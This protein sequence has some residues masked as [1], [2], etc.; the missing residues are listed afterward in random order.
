MSTSAPTVPPS[1]RAGEYATL[2]L[3]FGLSTICVV[4]RMYTKARLLKSLKSED[5]KSQCSDTQ[6]DERYADWYDMKGFHYSATLDF[7]HGWAL[8]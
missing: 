6:P 8:L 5:C 4:T 2:I 1:L 7:W 3:G